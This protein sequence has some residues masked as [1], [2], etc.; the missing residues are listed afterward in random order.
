[1]QPKVVM[2]DWKAVHEI[3]NGAELVQA[4]TKLS[5]VKKALAFILEKKAIHTTHNIIC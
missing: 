3:T 2:Q 1:M 5:F 4:D